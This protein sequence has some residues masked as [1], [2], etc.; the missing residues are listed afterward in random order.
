MHRLILPG[1]LILGSLACRK[2]YDGDITSVNREP[3]ILITEPSD[4]A[5]YDFG[6][7]IEFVALVTDDGPITQITSATWTSDLTGILHDSTGEIDP[8]GN[9]TYTTSNIESGT[10]TVTLQVIDG[11]GAPAAEAVTIT[12]INVPDEPSLTVVHPAGTENGAE[13]QPYRFEILVDDAQDDP[14]DLISVLEE[15]TDDDGTFETFICDLPADSAGVAYCED[16]MSFGTHKLRFTTTDTEGF[17]ATRLINFDV[18]SELDHDGDGDGWTDNE[19]DC[20]DANA[21]VYP[22]APEICDTL[23]NDCSDTTPIDVG[24]DCYDDDGDGYCEGPSC[25][26]GTTP[27][28]CDDRFPQG[29]PIHPGASETPSGFPDGLDNDCDNLIDEGTGKWDDDGDN[30][31]ENPPCNNASGTEVDCDDGNPSISPVALEV[32]DGVDNDCDFITDPANSNGCQNYYT[33]GDG[34]GYAAT[35]ASS[36]CLCSA[37]APYTVGSLSPADCYDS[38]ANAYPGSN[39]WRT[40]QRGDGSF[41]YNCDGAGEKRYNSLSFGCINGIDVLGLYK[42]CSQNGSDGWDAS[43]PQCGNSGGW[44][45]DCP[46]LWFSSACSVVCAFATDIAACISQCSGGNCVGEF[47]SRQQECR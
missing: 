9:I 40:L 10:H 13:N 38:N 37:S 15:D 28:D 5:E 8:D 2:G 1:M 19:G 44:V 46:D 3:I 12:I 32:C 41:D 22:T 42:S 27:G 33:D 21:T 24:T 18:V 30:Y 25:S 45:T 7:P 17:Q 23:D 4:G 11:N 43:V 34:D 31:C 39:S 36:Q 26:D 20:N 35:G 6:E 29:T 16:I 14:R 47:Q